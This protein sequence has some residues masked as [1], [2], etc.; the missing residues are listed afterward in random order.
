MMTFLISVAYFLGDDG[1]S[2]LLEWKAP[3]R[4]E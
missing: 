3:P 1:N 4:I 2:V